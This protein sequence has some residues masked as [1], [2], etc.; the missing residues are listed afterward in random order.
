M[1]PRDLAGREAVRAFE[2]AGWER[3]RTRGSHAVL[4][5]KG[6]TFSLSAP[7]HDRLDRGTLRGLIR[8]ADMTVDEFL[9]YLG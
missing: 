1:L 9:K 5:R 3:T 6:A 8:D 2:R 4:V 7:L